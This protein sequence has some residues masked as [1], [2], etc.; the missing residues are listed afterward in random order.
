MRNL[1]L[2]LSAAALAGGISS[3]ETPSAPATTKSAQSSEPQT[4]LDRA[5]ALFR[6]FHIN[7]KKMDWPVLWAK[8]H[9]AAADAK[10]PADTYPA[11]RLIIKELGEKHTVFITPDQA[12]AQSTGK[13]TNGTKPPIFLLPDGER[14][15]EGVGV[16]RLY[17]FSG[18]Q[19]QARLYSDY[20][21]AKIRDFQERGICRFVID[22]RPNTGGNMYPMIDAVSALL[23]DGLLGTFEDAAGNFTPWILKGGT[24]TIG[25]ITASP[26]S[27]TGQATKTFPVAV[28]LGPVTASAGEYTAMSFKGRAN[29][30]FFG[31]PTA[32]YVT[33]NQPMPLSDGA[34][35]IMTGARGIDRTGKKYVDVV[36]PDE[37]TGAGGP[38]L[39]AAV[40][41]LSAQRCT[42][43]KR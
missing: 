24:A 11:I 9:A 40:K 34:V 16:V 33:A 41:W 10:S 19:E 21:Q 20:G 7:S 17:G 13:S 4:Y 36:E 22:L 37:I 43:R 30:R 8:A 27:P 39:D 2:A 5:I 32:G 14:L 26:P 12:K 42:A 23:D 6:Q 35:I 18:S 29:T 31:T 1:V 38:A 28:L 25:P 15:A 3:A